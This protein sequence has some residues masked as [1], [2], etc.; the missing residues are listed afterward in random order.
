[1]WDVWKGHVRIMVFDTKK[2]KSVYIPEHKWDRM[3]AEQKMR[4]V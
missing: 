1:M 4:Y 3:S 2:K